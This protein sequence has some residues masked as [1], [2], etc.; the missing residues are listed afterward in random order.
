MTATASSIDTPPADAPIIQTIIDELSSCPTVKP[1][2]TT[3]RAI[4]IPRQSLLHEWIELYWQSLER[5]D[6]LEWASAFD[7]DLDTFILK[8]NTLHACTLGDGPRETRTFDLDD[9]S[10]WWQ[11]A[12]PILAIARIIDPAGLG[13]PYVG[14]KSANPRYEIARRIVL[15]FYGYPEPENRLQAQVIINELKASGLA[16]T[17]SD[18]HTT[19]ALV[20]ERNAQSRDL[21]AIADALEIS[22]NT[23]EQQSLPYDRL[24]L[25][26]TRVRLSDG[27]FFAAA[28]QRAT[29]ALL[30]VTRHPSF[31]AAAGETASFTRY[32]Y[33]ARQQK[34]FLIASDGTLTERLSASLTSTVPPSLLDALGAAAEALGA[35]VCSDYFFSL[36]QLL[37]GYGF[38][39]PD[40]L[41]AAWERVSQL[42]QKTWKA[43]PSVS[44]FLRA[45]QSIQGW[46]QAFA[47]TEDC[48]H[49]TRSLL[50]LSARRDDQENISLEQASRPETGSALS[51]AIAEGQPQLLQLRG[52]AKIQRLLKRK[53]LSP[54]SRLAL[55][56]TGE[57]YA[58]ASDHN[59]T[60]LTLPVADQP[61]LQPLIN[62]LKPLALAAGGTL[63]TDGRAS[64]AQ[65]LTFY[66]IP[67][68]ANAGEARATALWVKPSQ[69][70]TPASMHHWYLLGRP[71]SQAKKLST[72]Q[73]QLIVG[74]TQAFMTNISEPLIDY[75]CDSVAG[76]LEASVTPAK[77]DAMLNQILTTPRAR[78]LGNYL[79]DSMPPELTG[80][81][82]LR[83]INR[84]RLVITALIL[85]LDPQAGRQPNKVL[86]QS[87]DDSF[88][89]GES[90]TEVRRFLTQQFALTR[91]K[92]KTLA[93]HLLLSGIAP[94]FLVRDIPE[95]IAY[96]SGYPSVKLTQIVTYLEKYAPAISRL[97]TYTELMTLTMHPVLPAV[98]DTRVQSSEHGVQVD[99]AVARGLMDGYPRTRPDDAATLSRGGVAFVKHSQEL[100][101]KRHLAFDRPLPTPYTVALADL[102]KVFSDNPYLENKCLH[103]RI[104]ENPDPS[105]PTPAVE[106]G[107]LYSLVELHIAN[108]L[109]P[110]LQDWQCIQPQLDLAQLK[111]GLPRLSA[112]TEQFRPLLAT[113]LRR[114]E[115][116]LIAMI[117]ELFCQRP[118]AQRLDL[119]LGELKLFSVHPVPDDFVEPAAGAEWNVPVGPFA[120]IVSC[121]GT[122]HR[123]YEVSLR[124]T[125]IVLRRDIQPSLLPIDSDS[126]PRTLPFD[127]RAYLKGWPPRSQ[128]TCRGLLK[129][130]PLQGAPLADATVKAIPATFT[131]PRIEAIA[132]TAVKQLFDVYE[133][134]ALLRL[135]KS[136]SLEEAA[137]SHERW[138]TFYQTLVALNP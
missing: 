19:S 130:L 59:G 2:D 93:T 121:T 10:G 62:A 44:D 49:M 29:Q 51:R 90:F 66:E 58:I 79:L 77:I 97:M 65:M 27:S 9:N 91:I 57:L 85:S 133:P 88:F 73:R 105:L 39:M 94:V 47:D 69:L 111:S 86:D 99:W 87:L 60:R 17:D 118:L 11:V 122:P 72:S 52:N 14:G 50:E 38:D 32:R 71:G 100:F 43:L 96:L 108:Q 48:R 80:R 131:S 8:G 125:C 4:S 3:P 132:R 101:N 31:T 7:I 45:R 138:L 76:E 116:A 126:V 63:R 55:D 124:D 81:R 83:P 119:E 40:S 34:F 54:H 136:P 74:L 107:P 117:K 115:A 78:K 110:G 42:R 12:A 61:K 70:M 114:M 75:L 109:Q 98:G 25:G 28:M 128:S 95:S 20:A 123:V 120:I 67:L 1:G 64:L 30:A 5:S 129:S 46:Q 21:C 26:E 135:K 18:G 22:I 37:E 53:R 84:E 36:D 41:A 24:K 56:A 92:Q 104:T 35:D 102:R 103:Q 6:F 89:W 106:T 68:P 33:S 113:R 23:R 134:K 82:E 16:G 13:L 127:A 112:V 15:E 137:Q